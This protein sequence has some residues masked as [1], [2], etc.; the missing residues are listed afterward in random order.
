[1][2]IP[3]EVYARHGAYFNL[4]IFFFITISGSIPILAQYKSC[5]KSYLKI[6]LNYSQVCFNDKLYQAI[7]CIVWPYIK[8][9]FTVHLTLIKP[10]FSDLLSYVTL[11][12]CS[13]GRSHTT[14]LT[15]FGYRLTRNVPEVAYSK[16]THTKL[17]IYV[18][19]AKTGYLLVLVDY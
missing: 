1:M 6:L 2:N 13:V 15:V 19:I 11:F 7:T 16:N 8:C 9:S 10:V 12:K 3:D 18:F 5:L 4:D 14:G 17:D